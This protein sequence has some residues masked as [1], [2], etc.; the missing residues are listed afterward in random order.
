[1]EFSKDDFPV[2]ILLRTDECLPA[3][4]ALDCCV[5]AVK[6]DKMGNFTAAKYSNKEAFIDEYHSQ[7]EGVNMRSKAIGLWR[8]SHEIKEGHYIVAC[9]PSADKKTYIAYAYAKVFLEYGYKKFDEEY[10]HAVDVEEWHLI[11]D[12]PIDISFDKKYF[13]RMPVQEDRMKIKTTLGL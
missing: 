1:M 3:D 11:E 5:L 6:E 9:K 8:L 12:T 10:A 7:Y 4:E 13:L 2:W